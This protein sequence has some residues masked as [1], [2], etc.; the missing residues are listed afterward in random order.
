MKELIILPVHG[1]GTTERNYAD[2]LQRRLRRGLGDT[3]WRKTLFDPIYYQD[4]IQANQERVWTDVASQ[5]R[6][7]WKSLRRFMLYAFSDAASLEHHSADPASAYILAQERIRATLSDILARGVDPATPVVLL[8]HSLGCQVLSNYIWDAGKDQGVWSAHPVQRP[9]DEI[10][11]LK[12]GTLRLMVSAGCNIP[13]FVAGL[14]T[15]R[16]IARPHPDFRWLN[17]YDKDDVLGWPLQPLS[18]GYRA[19][20]ERDIRINSG[21]PL[22]AWTPWSHTDYWTDQEF[23]KHAVSGIRDLLA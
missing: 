21:G 23:L 5:A 10:N 1:M 19:L 20:V 15:I 6:V 13:L 4:L 9:A 3:A 11:F 7:A 17:I 14:K 2:E 8:P 16:P 12:L 18:P 22:T